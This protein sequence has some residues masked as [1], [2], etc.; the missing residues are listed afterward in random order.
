[1]EHPACLRMAQFHHVEWEKRHCEELSCGWKVDPDQ[2]G[3]FDVE[4]DH[5]KWTL[6]QRFCQADDVF[7]NLARESPPLV[8]YLPIEVSIPTGSSPKL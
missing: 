5:E 8:E 3:I 6:E 4:F 2:S 7:L 1:M